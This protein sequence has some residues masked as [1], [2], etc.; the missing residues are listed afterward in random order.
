MKVKVEFEVDDRDNGVTEGDLFDY[1]YYMH[2]LV[3]TGDRPNKGVIKAMGCD[4]K[5]V[6][7]EVSDE[8]A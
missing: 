7:I 6:G 4:Y 1:F 3:G 8:E 5:V 2:A